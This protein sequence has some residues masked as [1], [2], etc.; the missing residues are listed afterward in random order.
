[1]LVRVSTT[2]IKA[3]IEGRMVF[4]LPG[5]FQGQRICATEAFQLKVV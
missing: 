4:I 1:M 3:L 2:I 5:Q